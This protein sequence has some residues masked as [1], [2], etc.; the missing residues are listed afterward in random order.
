MKASENHI[1]VKRGVRLMS[2]SCKP[3]RSV[4]SD[5]HEVNFCHS[6]VY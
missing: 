4:L 2:L 6:W 5:Y 3:I 1:G